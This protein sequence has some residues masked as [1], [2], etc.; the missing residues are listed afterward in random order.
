MLTKIVL[1]SIIGGLLNLD[2]RAVAQVMVSRPIVV[3]PLV[4]FI[5]GYISGD[6]QGG[7]ANGLLIGAILELI[8]IRAIPVGTYVP[9]N[10]CLGSALG[11]GL[12]Q[13][14]VGERIVVTMVALS[15]AILYGSVV[16]WVEIKN[17]SFN[18]TLADF[19]LR[20]VRAGK[21]NRAE[22]INILSILITFLA[23]VG[24]LLLSLFIG[25]NLA[26]VIIDNLPMSMKRG[27]VLS[28]YLL[29]LLG[30]GAALEAFFRSKKLLP[31]FCIGLVLTVSLT[32]VTG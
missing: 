11:V 20:S 12:S 16:R 31:Y 19:I 29:P 27:F 24:I 6:P 10:A 18:N 30:L 13:M 15:L 17:R 8:W 2:E 32:L 7:L 22:G 4:G 9:P 23:G 26:Q 28:Y 25:V 3:S 5:L 14:I 1:A 21:L